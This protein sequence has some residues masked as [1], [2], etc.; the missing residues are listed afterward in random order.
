MSIELDNT[1]II[2]NVNNE[3]TFEV[4]FVK[5]TAC[6]NLFG[7][8]DLHDHISFNMVHAKN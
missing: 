6:Q 1:S 2:I 8:I 3:T 7:C 5:G 4:D